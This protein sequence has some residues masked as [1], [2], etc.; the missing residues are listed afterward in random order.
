MEI[1]RYKNILPAFIMH[2]LVGWK[3]KL[4][5][6]Q[7]RLQYILAFFVIHCC[8]CMIY[9]ILM[10]MLTCLCDLDLTIVTLTFHSPNTV[11]SQQQPG[12]KG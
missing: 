6:N 12:Q 11:A 7:I 9:N 1:K 3:S 5:C 2:E 8:V 10:S 4:S